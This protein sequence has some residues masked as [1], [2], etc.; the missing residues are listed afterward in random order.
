MRHP[1]EYRRKQP[2]AD[3]RGP[4]SEVEPSGEKMEKRGAGQDGEYFPAEKSA[5]WS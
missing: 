4:P 1:E 2:G 5:E 3:E